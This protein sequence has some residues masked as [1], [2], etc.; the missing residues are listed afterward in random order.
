[1]TGIR[2]GAGAAAPAGEVRAEDARAP[3]LEVRGLTKRFGKFVAVNDL[4]LTVQ[5]GDVYGF[6]GP[7]G[8]GKSTTIRAILGLVKP[9]EGE[10]RLLGRP[11]D[12][13]EGRERV[14]GFVEA[15]GFYEYLSARDNLRLLAA[16]D[17]RKAGS[18]PPIQRVLE[19][20]GLTGRAKDKVGAY[21][22]GMKQRLAIA[23]ALLREPEFLVLDEPTNGLD[24]AG[25]RDIRALVRRLSAE[26]LT[27]FLSTHLLSE[28]EQLCNRVAVVSRGKLVAEGSMREILEGFKVRSGFRLQTNDP[29]RAREILS[30]LPG[31]EP[32]DGPQEDGEVRLTTGP[33]GAGPVVR[34]LVEGGVEV[35]AL[36]PERPNLEELFIELTESD[37]R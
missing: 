12:G 10:I 27:I 2:V 23:A 31:A 26:G 16:A 25:M 22:Q 3:A 8:S 15:P 7:N 29:E 37:G 24:P 35:R 28:V 32:A 1:L 9:T 33:G 30:G 20:V 19:I 11:A 4:S 21:S 34:A 14:A 6:L 36:V 5:R 18:P 13:P 17:R